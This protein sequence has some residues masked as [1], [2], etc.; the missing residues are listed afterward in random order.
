VDTKTGAQRHRSGRTIPAGLN[1]DVIRA[2]VLSFYSDARAD[3]VIGPIFNAAIADQ[4]WPSHLDTITNFWCSMLLGTRSYAGQPMS[5]HLS[6]EG[7]EDR[8]FERWLALF[9]QTVD[10]ICRPEAAALL[11]DRAERVAH[12]F[13]IGIAIHRGQ[14]S[15][16]V[17]V[18]RA[19][20][21]G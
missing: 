4:D 14:D 11:V 18:M 17:A 9:R 15:L 12:S 5:K 10:R 13:R 21:V 19:A 1:E 16:R 20:P 3:P 7:L 8:H 2:V 6:L